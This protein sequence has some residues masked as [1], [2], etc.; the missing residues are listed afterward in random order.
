MSAT[1]RVFNERNELETMYQCE[2]DECNWEGPISEMAEI[3][4]IHER[5]MPGELVAAG[6]C[7]ECGDLIG[8]ADE[9][10]PDY[11][12]D[13]CIEIARSRGKFDAKLLAQRDALAQALCLLLPYVP[14]YMEGDYAGR[15]WLADAAAL[16]SQVPK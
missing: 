16:V 1:I 5:V 4:D 14:G 8:I 7:P 12:V 15:P 6:C 13:N 11:T 9:D 10:V 3:D 2:N